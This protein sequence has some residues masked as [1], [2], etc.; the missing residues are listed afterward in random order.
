MSSDNFS[1]DIIESATKGALDW[2]AEKISSLVRK[3]R[4]RKL[5]FIK[6]QKT[7]EI[8]REQYHSGEAKFYEKY[9]L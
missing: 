5:A 9:D 3:F 6:E 4:E 1:S 2:T 8:A 7:I